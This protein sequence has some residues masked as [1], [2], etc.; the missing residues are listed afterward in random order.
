MVNILVQ[1]SISIYFLFIFQTIILTWSTFA[2]GY[3]VYPI[4]IAIAVDEGSAKDAIML[5]AS[6][7]QTAIN[8]QNVI[9]YVVACGLNMDKAELLAVELNA[10][11]AECVP[12][13]NFEVK[14]FTLSKDSGF[15]LQTK[16]GVRKQ[17]YS[18]STGADIARFYVPS[19]FSQYE[20]MIYLDN[21]I[22]VSCCLEELWANDFTQ[23]ELVGI[24]LDSCPVTA[25]QQYT[26]HYNASHPLVM[27][28]F[29]GNDSDPLTSTT[30]M[31]SLSSSLI[32]KDEFRNAVPDYPNDG[33]MLINI[34]KYNQEGILNR[35]NTIAQAN[36]VDQV[37][38][39]GS[40][41]YTVLLFHRSWKRLSERFNM[42]HLPNYSKNFLILFQYNGFIHYAGLQFK[43]RILCSQ[44][45]VVNS[46]RYYSYTPWATV[47]SILNSTC[48][49][50]KLFQSS[51][52]CAEDI[53]VAD[54]LTKFLHLV[55]RLNIIYHGDAN[56]HLHF[57]MIDG[58]QLTRSQTGLSVPAVIESILKS[59]LTWNYVNVT[60]VRY[61]G[62]LEGGDWG[63]RVSTTTIERSKPAG[64][65]V[66]LTQQGDLCEA[67]AN[68]DWNA[69]YLYGS[70][71]QY[72]NFTLFRPENRRHMK[73]KTLLDYF[74]E[75]K[76]RLDL[77]TT[78]LMTFRMQCTLRLIPSN[79][80]T[81]VA[82]DIV[83]HDC[84][85][86]S[87]FIHSLP[88]LEFSSKLLYINILF[89]VDPS[90]HWPSRQPD[91][92]KLPN[93]VPRLI[94]PCATLLR[95][96]ITA[97]LSRWIRRNG[98]L[99]YSHPPVSHD[100]DALRARGSAYGPYTNISMI[101]GT[102]MDVATCRADL[103]KY[104]L[105]ER[106]GLDKVEEGSASVSLW[107]TRVNVLELSRANGK[108]GASV[109]S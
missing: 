13:V 96:Y 41:Q 29:R 6:I 99:A 90:P 101:N 68:R 59:N 92:V 43:P 57:N 77:S 40:L 52:S 108:Q 102:A 61:F 84:F 35:A 18:S 50:A 11:I 34:R 55:E 20:R 51:L 26:R 89:G 42:R 15:F 97:D 30:T 5:I 65:P 67:T 9:V 44:R 2:K 7:H 73:C 37:I 103:V 76:K 31:T 71:E 21:D 104:G 78:S 45:V 91:P 53:P 33:V 38:S 79:S 16:K 100:L 36:A 93:S 64:G 70:M 48:P 12:G 105:K 23:N 83:I 87:A 62:H 88:M 69:T 56:T 74:N 86:P 25:A 28:A 72:F 81:S 32:T 46:L 107:G 14:P 1:G 60:N 8:H 27:K 3:N 10:R 98:F 66:Y 75:K 82:R 94:E 49:R 39:A 80:I 95:Y 22:I 106:E 54:T 47:M 85:E 58:Q 63:G 109:D 24:V 17:H 4:R 19:I